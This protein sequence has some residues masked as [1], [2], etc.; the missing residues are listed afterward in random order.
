M[1]SAF[2]V[3]TIVHLLISL[4]WAGALLVVAGLALLRLR[5]T[6]SG[7]LFAGGFGVWALHRL[8]VFL[9]STL[10]VPTMDDPSAYLAVQSVVSTLVGLL[11][12]LAIGAAFAMLPRSLQRLAQRGR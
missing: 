10:L 7:L 3:G 8:L 2:D 1:S 9:L 6:I 4:V 11:E 12:L 5:T